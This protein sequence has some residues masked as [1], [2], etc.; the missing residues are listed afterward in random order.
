VPL[1]FSAVVLV[2]VY[3]VGKGQ[4]ADLRTVP[5]ASADVGA[6]VPLPSPAQVKAASLPDIMVLLCQHPLHASGALCPLLRRQ[7]AGERDEEPEPV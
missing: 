5:A 1:L 7:R 6:P 2:S 3:G 4:P